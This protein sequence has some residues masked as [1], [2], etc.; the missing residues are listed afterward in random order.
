M[1]QHPSF[2]GPWTQQKLEILRRYL[3]AY[4]RVLKEQPSADTPFRLTYVDAYAGSGSYQESNSDQLADYGDF[5]TFRQ[6]SAKIALDIED[7]PFDRLIYIEKNRRF[8][9]SLQFMKEANPH[10]SIEVINRDANLVLPDICSRMGSLDRAVIFLDPFATD[11]DWATV[12]AIADS[13]KVDC[14]I[15]FPLSALTRMMTRT[16]RPNAALSRKLDRIFGGREYWEAELYPLAAQQPLFG[17]GDLVSREPQDRIAEV[18]RNRIGNA[19][20]AIAPTRR[21]F[22]N[23]QNSPIFELIFAAANPA[24]ARRAIPIA[25]RLL[26]NF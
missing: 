6:G 15:W 4:T 5:D 7:K 10:R 21:K 26:K 20:A 17:D 19:F 18:Y 8:T 24:G 16:Q 1:T 9:S 11:V 12:Q 22:L 13:K 3:D 14:W 23:R 25:D 2:G